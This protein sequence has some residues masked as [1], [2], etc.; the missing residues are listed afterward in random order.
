MWQVPERG[1]G[2]KI[3]ACVVQDARTHSTTEGLCTALRI[4]ARD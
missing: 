4:T 2:W 1:A 3:E